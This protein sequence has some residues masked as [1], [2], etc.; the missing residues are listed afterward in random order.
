MAALSE[1]ILVAVTTKLTGLAQTGT[2]VERGRVYPVSALPALTVNMGAEQA[3]DDRNLAFQDEFLDI[4]ILAYVQDNTG[5]D[6]AL[7][8]VVAEVYAAMMADRT[9][10]L[11]YVLDTEWQGR[12]A[13]SRTDDLEKKTAQQAMIFRIHY[14]HSYTSMES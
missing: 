8:Q 12:D 1:S 3:V 13:P 14:R 2:R 9:Q 5:V 7:N 11:A 4:E 6:T 10:G